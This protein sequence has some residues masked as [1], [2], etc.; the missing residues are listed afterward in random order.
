MQHGYE[1]STLSEFEIALESYSNRPL[2][3]QCTQE[4]AITGNLMLCQVGK[5]VS[6]NVKRSERS[7][8]ASSPTSVESRES[9][10]DRN[11]KEAMYLHTNSK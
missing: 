11:T 9:C 4:T 7:A 8:Q 10:V 5:G 1:T 6:M 3:I 2:N